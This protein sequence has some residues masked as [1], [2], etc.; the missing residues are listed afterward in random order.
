MLEIRSA[1]AGS[2]FEI[3]GPNLG[4][5]LVRGTPLARYQAPLT[6]TRNYATVARGIRLK[7]LARIAWNGF[8]MESDWLGERR[9]RISRFIEFSDL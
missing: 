8:E 3:R 7:S 1:F 5:E 4:R 6:P 9:L 2:S